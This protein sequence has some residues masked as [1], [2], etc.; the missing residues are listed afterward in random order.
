[1]IVPI[2]ALQAGAAQ[3]RRQRLRPP[4]RG[5]HR[6]RDRRR[7]PISSTG[8]RSSCRSPYSRLEQKVEERTRDLAQSVR[9]LKALEE[10]GRAVASSLDLKSV[11]ATIVT[12]AVEIAHADAG[13]IYEY[14]EAHRVFR[15]G[16]GARSRSVHAWRRSARCASSATRAQLGEAAK[17]REPIV[18]PDLAERPNYPLR[19]LTL[20]AGF[21]SALVVPLVGAEGILG[22][23]VVQRRASGPIPGEHGRPD[24][25]LRQPVG[26]RHAQ[27]PA[28]PR[29]GGEGRPACR[30]R[31]STSRSSSPT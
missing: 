19:D 9:E 17:Q 23:L 31:T 20:A 12:R 22:S 8:W 6:R 29:G 13:A 25:D 11:L 24:A 1:M 10:I 15:P 14:D 18:I 21:H 16:R 28:V 26:A 2:R 27:C 3:A 5:A 4:H 7:S 30:S